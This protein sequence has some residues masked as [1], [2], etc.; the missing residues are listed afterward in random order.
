MHKFKLAITATVAAALCAA[1][2]AALA[3]SSVGYGRITAVNRVDVPNAGYL[4]IRVT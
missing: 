2:G 4:R 3:Q 1:A